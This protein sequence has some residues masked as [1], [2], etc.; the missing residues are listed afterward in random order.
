[1]VN[2]ASTWVQ[3]IRLLG[4]TP[5]ALLI[6]LLIAMVT[7]GIARGVDK[8]SLEKLMESSL[9]AICSVVLITGAGGMFGGV[10]RTSGIGAAVS[11]SMSAMGV[12]V[13]VA[14]FLIA[15]LLRIA[16]GSATVALMTTAALIK[17]AVEAGGFSS[18]QVAAIVLA[19][20]A[21]SVIASHVNDSGFWLVGRLMNLDVPTTFKTWTVME[22]LI[23]IMGFALS[24]VIYFAM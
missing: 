4:S 10:L 19:A 14:A 15:S 18:G 17:P 8:L 24:L 6:T 3:I 13:I 5:V 11:S 22:T 23:A 7:L 1:M 12:P 2:G 21:G 20:S 16:Q 9:P